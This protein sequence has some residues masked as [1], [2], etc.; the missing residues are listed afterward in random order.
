M[1][2]ELKLHN[3]NLINAMCKILFVVH[4]TQKSLPPFIID[5]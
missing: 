4:I 3:H 2:E 1:L 5:V